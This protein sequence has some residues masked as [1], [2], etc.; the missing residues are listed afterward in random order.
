MG[1]FHSLM[2]RPC[3]RCR[4]RH[5]QLSKYL[6]PRQVQLVQCTW[7]ILKMDLTTLGIT[8]FLHLFDSEPDLKMLFPKLIRMN[9]SNQLEWDVDKEMLQ[10]HAV[11]VMEGL[12]A[13][14]ETLH[15]SQLLNSVLIA[16]GQT[17]D[18]RN[19]KPHMLKRMWPSM[20]VG[21]AAVLGEG[22]TKEVSEAWRK[23]YSY[24]CLQMVIGMKNPDL[25]VDIHEDLSES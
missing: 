6:T 18:K 9:D 16:L 15:D 8:V 19:I 17:H 25:Y 22:Y 3:A 14:V 4:R 11:T 23:L 21:L 20:H 7:S 5:C 1:M 24:I 2:C 13:A 12:G 10:K